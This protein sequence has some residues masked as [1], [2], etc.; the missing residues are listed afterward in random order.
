MSLHPN[1]ENEE[2]RFVPNRVV[3]NKDL[4]RWLV[5]EFDKMSVALDDI[6]NR[7]RRVERDVDFLYYL[8]GFRDNVPNIRPSYVEDNSD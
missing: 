1:S 5:D 4:E 6:L 7:L 3:D 8:Q 2:V